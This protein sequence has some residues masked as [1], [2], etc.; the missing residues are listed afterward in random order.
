[1]AH[2]MS[3]R[4]DVR[5][6]PSMIWTAKL[7]KPMTSATVM[8]ANTRTTSRSNHTCQAGFMATDALRARQPK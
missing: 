8:T 2:P 3:S 7:P 1:M 5:M 4:I 6:A